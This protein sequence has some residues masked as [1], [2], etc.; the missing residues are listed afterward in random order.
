MLA[1]AFFVILV[2]CMCA[3][4]F[5]G[6]LLRR[7]SQHF[8]FIW[9]PLLQ[10]RGCRRFYLLM[11]GIA[12]T[13]GHAGATARS[14]PHGWNPPGQGCQIALAAAA[15]FASSPEG[16]PKTPSPINRP[17]QPHQENFPR[18]K[19]DF[20]CNS[21]A[22]VLQQY[23]SILGSKYTLRTYHSFFPCQGQGSRM[24]KKEQL[25]F[26]FTYFPHAKN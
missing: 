7:C 19:K 14:I 2:P 21:S 9:D 5:V 8:L 6:R 4:V 18:A 15:L 17:T 25:I 10:P 22:I 23:E 1:C 12:A 26:L 16:D 20:F 13:S 24:T 11:H 3:R